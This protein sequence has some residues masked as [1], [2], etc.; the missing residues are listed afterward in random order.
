M[1]SPDDQ[2]PPG[3]PKRPRGVLIAS[4]D[5]DGAF[6]LME[7]DIPPRTLIAPLH[8]HRH[9]DEY[10]YVLYGTLGAQ[11]ADQTLLADPHEL[12]L[13]R[14]SIPHTLWN[15]NDT[16]TRVLELIVPGG[17]ERCLQTLYGPGY[18]SPDELAALWDHY[19]IEMQPGSVPTLMSRHQ[20]KDVATR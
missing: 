2:P 20:L 15:P 8:T 18:Y 12:V 14:K 10:T 1:T 3:A 16:P 6:A 4:Q 19:G 17:F 9:E 5:N 11:I 7:Y 13:K